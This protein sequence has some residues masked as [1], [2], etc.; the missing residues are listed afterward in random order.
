MET[1]KNEAAQTKGVATSGDNQDQEAEK[2]AKHKTDEVTEGPVSERHSSGPGRLKKTAM[3]L[4]G[5]KKGICTLPS[6]FGGGRNKGS[7][8]NISKKGLRKSK[9]HDG[10]SEVAH[11]AK[12]VVSEETGYSLPFPGSLCQFPS[13]QSTHG[14]L[15]IGYRHKTSVAGAT[16]NV[17]ADKIA[18]APKP[19][20]GLKD[21]FNSIR[22]HRKSRVARAEQSEPWAKAPEGARARS[23]EHVSSV[24]VPCSEETLQ[25]PAKENAKPQDT[26]GPK[27]SPAPEP[28]LPATE[29]IACKNL[30]KS[31]GISASSLVQPKLAPEASTLEESHRQMADKVV[32]AELNPPNGPMGDQLSLLFGDVTSLKSFDSL[33]GCGDIIAEQDMDSMTDSMASGGQRANRD[34]TKRSSCLVTYQGGGEEMALP[35]DDEEEEEEDEEVELEEEEEA[36]EEEDDDLEY[37]WATAQMYPRPNLNLDYHSTTS[38]GH[39]G[40]V[41][42][43]SVQS[44]AGLAPGE[45]LTPQSDQQESAPNS[46]EGYYDS[47]TPGFEDDSGE[48]LGLV[49][50]DCLPRDS[51]SGD[52]LY[53]FYEPDDSLENSPPED[54]CLYDLHGHSSEI[55]DPFLNFE[56]FS[57]SRPPGAME[58]EEER[59]VTIQK[60][61]LYWELRREQ[62]EAWETCAREVHAR[63]PHNRKAYTQEAH[64]IEACARETQTWES[65]SGEAETQETQGPEGRAIEVKVQEAQA[66]QEKPILEYQMRPLGPSVMGLVAGTSEASQTSHQGST[67]AFPATASSE[68]DWRDFRPLE[69]RFEGTCSKK[70]QS[71]CLMQLFQNSAMFDPDTQEVNFGGSLRRAYPTYSPPAEPEEG[72]E[73]EGNVAVSFSQALVEFTSNGNLF[74]SMSCSSDSDSSFTQN[75]PELP[76]M[77][78]FDIVDVER[79]GEGKCEENPEFHNNEDLAASLEAFEL[80]CYHKHAFNNYHSRFYQ[81]LSW[82]VSSLP[83]YLGLPGMHRRPPPAAIALNRR[84]RSLD[85]AETLELELSN[86]HLAQGCL[87]SELQA[88]QEDS[89]EEDEGEEEWGRVSSLSLYTE[90]PGAYRWSTWAPC[91][92]PVRPCPAWINSSQLGGPSSQSPYGQAACCVPPVAMSAS[93]PEPET[94]A[95]GESRP[96]I[97]R[98]SHLPLPMGPCYDLQPQASQSVRTRPQDVLVPADEPSCSSSTGRFSPSPLHQAKPVGI[99]HGIP[100]LPRVQSE[101]SQPQPSHYRA[102]SLDLSKEKTEQGASL[103]T[104]YSSTAMNGN[105]AK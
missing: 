11:D 64:A 33:T 37:L 49:H 41:L 7:G 69:K 25:A 80:G 1:Q 83:R 78:T 8:K 4:F 14:A 15:E 94:I 21:F 26:P 74:S 81:G 47:T 42:L 38:P 68:P 5:G 70:D 29:K 72:G 97:A 19:K 34:G 100:Q 75:L 92:L 12:D 54:D 36:K 45:L 90:P 13:S 56:P 31:I 104:S 55:F 79:E 71:T 87:D 77:V 98:P 44:Y 63:E 32:L 53:E 50:R 10:L 91:P 105:L 6:F 22:R 96:Q 24:P 48:A 3:K 17:G 40:Y 89:D 93:G 30:E 51:Y 23:H 52:A 101:S 20:K 9:T 16:K 85:T 46:D 35:D 82:G 67:S 58:T 99:T 27:I 95:P 2:G 62:L 39:H 102:S 61:L 18:P 65:H 60:Q 43:D 66:W 84:S 28:S 76:P 73:K 59:L 57:S 103:P 86:S 88:Q